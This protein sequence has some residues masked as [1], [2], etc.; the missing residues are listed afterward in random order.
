MAEELFDSI[1]KLIRTDAGFTRL[2]NVDKQPVTLE[3]F[4]E[5]YIKHAHTKCIFFFL[6]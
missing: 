6:L 4:Q 1:N 5:R 2:R 3:N